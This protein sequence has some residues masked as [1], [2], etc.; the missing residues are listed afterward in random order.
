MP[1]ARDAVPLL[2]I[3]ARAP[4]TSSRRMPLLGCAG[5][6][7]AWLLQ[8]G[9][10]HLFEGRARA[11]DDPR[12]VAGLLTGSMIL[13][14]W[15]VAGTIFVVGLTER[16]AGLAAA[17]LSITLFT[18]YFAGQMISRP[19]EPEREARSEHKGQLAS[20]SASTSGGGGA[21]SHFARTAR[22]TSSSPAGSS[23]TPD[24]S[25]WAH[26]PLVQ[27]GVLYLLLPA[28][29]RRPMVYVARPDDKPNRVDRGKGACDSP[30]TRRQ[31]TSEGRRPSGAVRGPALLIWLLEHDRLL[32]CGERARDDRVAAKLAS[33]RSYAATATCRSARAHPTVFTSTRGGDPQS[34]PGDVSEGWLTA[35]RLGPPPFR[36]SSSR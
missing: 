25:S 24:L 23:S 1:P 15:M 11:S 13:R 19:F 28:C 5:A 6:A 34:T 31:N 26:R 29:H 2:V 22:T 16:E 8:R 10:Q 36:S 7:G 27:Q 18:F 12:T 4:P 32:P 35:G 14:G 33:L 30:S 3:L 17:I 21:L 9:V 20:G